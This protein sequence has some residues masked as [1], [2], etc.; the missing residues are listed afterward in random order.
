MLTF[1]HPLAI[2]KARV[3]ITKMIFV[4]A[5]IIIKIMKTF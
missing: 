3:L 5:V 1:K 4:I 2:I